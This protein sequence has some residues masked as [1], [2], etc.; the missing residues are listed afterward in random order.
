MDF[1]KTLSGLDLLRFAMSIIM[2]VYHVKSDITLRFFEHNGWYAT[3]TFFILSGFILTYVYQDK[4]L[5]CNFSTADFLIK[6]L[7]ALYPIH[8]ATMAIYIA[9]VPYS[10]FVKNTSVF[11][12]EVQ[13]QLIPNFGSDGA[14]ILIGLSDWLSYLIESLFLVHAWD[15]RYLLFNGP[16]WSISTLFF[17]YCLFTILVKK[18]SNI[19]NL[20]AF[21][22]VGWLTI[23]LLPIYLV[24]TKNF[25]SDIIGFMHRNPLARL[26][27][28]MAGICLYYL[29]VKHHVFIKKYSFLLGLIGMMGF[30]LCNK[31][32]ELWSA[33]VFYLTHNGLFLLMQMALVVGFS[34]LDFK[35]DYLKQLFQ[36]LGRTSLTIYLLHMPAII[37]YSK[38]IGYAPSK[39][40]LLSD[41]QL[42]V[43]LLVLVFASYIIQNK[44]FTPLQRYLAKKLIAKRQ[45]Y[46]YEPEQDNSLKIANGGVRN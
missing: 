38:V 21:T 20:E 39:E 6:R 24:I 13:A 4:I 19:K 7:A 18:I 22:V 33:N 41:S 36:K 26:P 14:V 11:P 42:T 29:L 12:F 30:Y 27:D 23:L 5:N 28:F 32:I 34:T 46:R 17:F 37:V 40:H 31:L 25:S 9:L 43:F 15:Y 8:I 10:L 44:F 45:A 16:S 3:S 1:K 35:S 2:V